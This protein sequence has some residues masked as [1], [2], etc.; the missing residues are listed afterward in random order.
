MALPDSQLESILRSIV[1]NCY[2][3]KDLESL[4]VK[5]VRKAAEEKLAL[6]EDFFKN[7]ERWKEKSKSVIQSEVVCLS[8]SLMI[9]AY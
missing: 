7:D 1:R 8:I 4:T 6:E 9:T 3:N 5:R 2:K